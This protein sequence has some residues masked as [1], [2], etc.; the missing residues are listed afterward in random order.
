MFPMTACS[1]LVV[2]CE[3]D[4]EIRDENVTM[5]TCIV[6]KDIFKFKFQINSTYSSNKNFM[7]TF[8]CMRRPLENTYSVQCPQKPT[9][10]HE[11]TPIHT[12][13]RE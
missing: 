4:D 1:Q 9:F 3:Y 7:N 11:W 6:V 10:G 8:L 13:I 2:R 5:V 12:H